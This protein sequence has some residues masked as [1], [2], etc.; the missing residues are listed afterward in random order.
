MF[1]SWSGCFAAKSVYYSC[2]EPDLS[3]QHVCQAADDHVTNYKGI[4]YPLLDSRDVI[5]NLES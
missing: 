1:R 4:P 3:C 5:H 2:K